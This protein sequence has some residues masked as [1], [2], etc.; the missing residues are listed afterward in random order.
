MFF[1]TFIILLNVV[2]C[3]I[4]LV[5]FAVETTLDLVKCDLVQTTHEVPPH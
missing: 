3:Y 5:V 1:V 4:N 2:E